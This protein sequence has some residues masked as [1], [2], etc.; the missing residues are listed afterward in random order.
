M[1]DFSFFG[2]E[3]FC[4][5][6]FGKDINALVDGL[7]VTWNSNCFCGHFRRASNPF[8]RRG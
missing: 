8:K 7:C 4:K 3:D 5:R 6:I 2:E 1:V